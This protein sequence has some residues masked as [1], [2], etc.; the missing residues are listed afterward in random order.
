MKKDI[1][2]KVE[3]INYITPPSTVILVSTISKDGVTNV[4]PFGMFMIASSKPPMV[5]LGISSKS[6]TYKN[7]CETKEFVVA[8]PKREMIDKLYKCGEKLESNI[9]EFDY[10]DI[11][12]YKSNNIKPLKVTE[13]S[14]NLECRLN[15]KKESGNHYIICGDVIDADIDEDI[16]EEDLTNAELRTSIDSIYHITGSEFAIGFKEQINA[17]IK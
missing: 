9:S 10:F 13:C 2:S 15:W 16:Y 4:A 1:Y 17:D 3:K 14:V 7:I 8:F 12:S 11:K 5:A 6:D